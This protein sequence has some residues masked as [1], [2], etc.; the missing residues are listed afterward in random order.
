MAQDSGRQSPESNTTQATTEKTSQDSAT[1]STR[2]ARESDQ[3]R[4]SGDDV[5]E[6]QSIDAFSSLEDGQPGH[7]G[8]FELQF[9]F[10]WETTS[11]EHDPVLF[12]PEL[13]FTLDGNEFLRNTKLTLSVPT[14]FGSGGVNGNAD[15]EFGWQQRWVTEEGLMPTLATLAEIRIP[16]GYHS[17]GVD[18]T[19]TGIVAKDFGPGTF[20][21]N[22]FAETANGH[23]VKDLRAFQWGLRAGYKW[24]VSDDFALIGGYVYS[25]SEQYGHGDINL[26]EVSGQWRVSETIT[27]GPGVFVGLDNNEETPNFG[28]GFRL[29]WS[30]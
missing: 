22:A 4:P 7:P 16:S 21:F 10:G 15:L 11:G 28:A 29:T 2:D 24:R 20:Y 23:N 5:A 9:D 12:K 3:F 19:L 30:P 25:S 18:G 27:I 1:I 26:L 17:S 6:R 13:K 8:R 14:E